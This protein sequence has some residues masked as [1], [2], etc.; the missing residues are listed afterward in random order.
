LAKQ[1]YAL[2]ELHENLVPF[3]RV[4]LEDEEGDLHFEGL[5]WDHVAVDR[6][7]SEVLVAVDRVSLWDQGE[8]LTEVDLFVPASHAENLAEAIHVEYGPGGPGVYEGADP[9]DPVMVPSVWVVI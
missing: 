6:A 4:Y 7:D 8:R 3:A 1:E 9:L 5:G 2:P